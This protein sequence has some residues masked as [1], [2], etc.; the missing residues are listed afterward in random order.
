[1]GRHYKVIDASTDEV[2]EAKHTAI[3]L[4]GETNT[5]N[6]I[7]LFY[8]DNLNEVEK[9]IKNLNEFSN[10]SWI[11]SSILLYTLI[12]SKELYQQAG[13][14]WAEY[15]I[16]SRERLGIDGRDLSEQ[17]S[18]ARFFIK[19]HA[20]LERAGFRVDSANRKLARAELALTLSGDIDAVISHL[21]SDTWVEFKEWY[22][23]FKAKKA[24][25]KSTENERNDIEISDGHYR[26]G[27]IDAVTVSDKIPEADRERISLY[28]SEIF[29]ALRLGYEPAIVQTYDK[30]E[31]AMLPRLRDKYRQGK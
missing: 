12:Y 27:G 18:A 17:L 25:P 26:I 14:T 31:A 23:S 29:E 6:A 24:L 9:G 7:D 2:E 30:K 4:I 10:K 15:A 19:H 3:S 13:L 28:L 16:Q 22:Q 11:L 8:L 1:M 20:A 5:S 21:V